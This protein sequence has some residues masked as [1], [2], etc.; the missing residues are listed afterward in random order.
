MRHTAFF[1]FVAMAFGCGS[2]SQPTAQ[3]AAPANEPIRT[4]Q[5]QSTIPHTTENQQPAAPIKPTGGKWSA[6]GTPIDTAKYDKA[7]A[8]AEKVLKAKPND[9]DAKKEVAKAYF[10]R[11]FALTEARQYASALGDY[12]R[13]LK[14]DPS[15]EEAKKWEQQIIGIYEMMKK[16]YPKPGEEPA[17]LPFKKEETK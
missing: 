4:G 2:N 13:T 5:M 6:D 17:P 10:E 16:E 8:D 11:G 14:N 1:L 9:A 12:R 7:I 15:H 3:N